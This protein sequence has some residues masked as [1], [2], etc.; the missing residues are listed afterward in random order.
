MKYLYENSLIMRLSLILF[1][2]T[3]ILA[4]TQPEPPSG[5]NLEELRIW[6]KQN[7]YDSEFSD[8]GYLQAREQM[9]GFVE[10]D[11]GQIECIYTGFQ[12]AG[13][14]ITFPNPINA[15]HAVPQSY[16]GSETPMRSDIHNIR[17]CHGS[18]NSARGNRP[19]GEVNDASNFYGVDENGDYFSTSSTPENPEEFTKGNALKWEPRDEYKGDIARQ[20]FYF[21][22]MYPTQAGS[23]NGIGDINEL[24]QWHLDDPVS[25]KEII[26]NNRISTAQG[27]LNPYIT[28][29]DAVYNA[30]FFL[31]FTGCTDPMAINFD[32]TASVDDG[33]C[34]VII[35]GCTC[36]EATNYNPIATLDDGSCSFPIPVLG[37]TYPDANN[38]SPEATEDNGT[39]IFELQNNCA[40]DINGNGLVDIQDILDILAEFGTSC[41]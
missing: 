19:Y 7:W 38:Y 33:S 39:C 12:Q 20:V 3:P 9:Y 27:N 41:N 30:W 13:G 11:G 32:S 40:A 35:E 36:D 4:Y 26:R 31:T 16:Y 23:I 29:P 28:H 18:V 8:L 17:P 10:N 14:F 37:C 6:L 24:Y 1:C 21:Y 15:E 22:T 2:L 25:A 5:L 34:V